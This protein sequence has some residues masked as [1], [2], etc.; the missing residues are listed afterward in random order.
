[1]GV[2]V[3]IC[4]FLCM[5]V[6]VC[7]WVCVCVFVWV[8]VGGSLSLFLSLSLSLGII[9]ALDIISSC[10]PWRSVSHIERPFRGSSPSFS[11]VSQSTTSTF[12]D[13][14]LASLYFSH[15]SCIIQ[16]EGF[17]GG[18]HR[19]RESRGENDDVGGLWT[20]TGDVA[21]WNCGL[22][23]DLFTANPGCAHWNNLAFHVSTVRVRCKNK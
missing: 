16:S 11:L 4:V 2:F 14:S 13:A 20:N 6:Y 21:V 3:S 15:L 19:E 5:C 8:W 9:S 18:W 22:D 23:Y 17:G 10:F 7:V 12:F 1:M